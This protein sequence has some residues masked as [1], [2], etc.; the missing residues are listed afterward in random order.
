MGKEE[1]EIMRK[2]QIRDRQTDVE[3][4][5]DLEKRGGAEKV[6]VKEIE[7]EREREEREKE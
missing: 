1:K 6:R 2:R 3:E 5:D 4:R 7:K